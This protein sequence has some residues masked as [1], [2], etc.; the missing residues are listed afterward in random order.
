M[1]V[2]KF[3]PTTGQENFS[4]TNQNKV[5]DNSSMFE[6]SSSSV[7]TTK[8]DICGYCLNKGKDH[9]MKDC[10]KKAT[11]DS[12]DLKVLEKTRTLSTETMEV[13]LE[14]LDE[15][16]IVMKRDRLIRSFIIEIADGNIIGVKKLIKDYRI[17]IDDHCPQDIPIL[18]Y[19]IKYDRTSILEYMLS[20]NVDIYQSTP[21][22]RNILHFT[23]RYN[24]I[25]CFKVICRYILEI[26]QKCRKKSRF[27]SLVSKKGKNNAM[28]KLIN[29]V[30]QKDSDG[31]TPLHLACRLTNSDIL[32][33]LLTIYFKIFKDPSELVDIF[34]E[35]NCENETILHVAASFRSAEVIFILFEKLGNIY[36]SS[37]FEKTDTT[38]KRLKES[39]IQMISWNNI[40]GEN[41]LFILCKSTC[42]CIKNVE[43][44]KK[45]NKS[46]CILKNKNY[47]GSFYI[48]DKEHC[49]NCFISIATFM[50]IIFK[51]RSEVFHTFDNQGR[52]PISAAAIYGNLLLLKQLV[53][54]IKLDPNT[55]DKYNRTPLHHASSRGFISMVKYLTEKC[56]V[57]MFIKDDHG[58]TAL[59]YA[60][61]KDYCDII[62]ILLIAN[63]RCDIKNSYGHTSLMWAVI[64]GCLKALE[65]IILLDPTHCRNEFDYDGFNAVH[66][67]VKFGQVKALK[68]LLENGWDIFTK[69][70]HGLNIIQVAIKANSVNMLEI[71][72]NDYIPI[73]EC[74]DF[75]NTLLHTAASNKKYLPILEYVL[76]RRDIKSKL[77]NYVNKDGQTPINYAASLGCTGAFKLLL[78]NDA[79]VNI[80][81]NNGYNAFMRAAKNNMWSVLTLVFDC[82]IDYNAVNEVEKKTLLDYVLETSNYPVAMFLRQQ[83]SKTI[84]E[85]ER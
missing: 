72:L 12:L 33:K 11:T 79:N 62:E 26:I 13:S 66:L 73:E 81:D 75:G 18:F 83:N 42:I 21:K 85:L 16:E 43:E 28:F 76:K 84:E 64:N 8:S 60:T 14:N 36:S 59:H 37:A 58:V 47:E 74:D 5:H 1:N 39:L 10:I 67:A 38:I 20:K 17:K 27:F 7:T 31:N 48:E 71:L 22:Q 40:I 51:Y 44:S 61:I 69:T 78:N 77:L 52:H 55:V 45:N 2:K 56:K 50:K 63:R 82:K 68:M 41:L 6:S 70:L 34:Q 25:K 32:Q 9:N 30:K 57:N 19:A 35:K 4:P 49:E 53:E 46:T 24:K 80:Q 54:L 3:S 29:L 23:I 65:K 15:T